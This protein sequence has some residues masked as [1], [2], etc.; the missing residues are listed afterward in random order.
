MLYK[1]STEGN[2]MKTIYTA[3]HMLRNPKTELDGGQLI[4]PWETSERAEIVR[5]RVE[6]VQLGSMLEPKDFGLEPIARIHDVNYLEFIKHCWQSWQIEG[7]KGEAI[8]SVWPA[9]GMRQKVP[10]GVTGQ[11]G[12]YSFFFD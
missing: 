3:D 7:N 5:R 6:Q 2:F 9:R 4:T 1:D 10:S 12:Y 8:P 11:L